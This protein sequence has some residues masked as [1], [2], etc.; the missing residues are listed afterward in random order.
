MDIRTAAIALIAISSIFPACTTPK[1]LEDPL[2]PNSRIR[3]PDFRQAIG[4]II[5][6]GVVGGNRVTTL[7]NGDQIFPSMLAAIRGAKKTIT[8][9]TFV[10]EKGDVPKAFAEAFAE[11][12]RAGVK[13]HLI[14]DAHGAKKSRVYHSMMETAGVQIVKYHPIFALD[15]RRYNNRTHRKLLVIDGKVAF[16]GGVGIADQWSGNAQSPEHWRDSHYRIEGPAVAQIQGAFI[17]NWMASRHELLF[18]PDYFP[19]LPSA[20]TIAGNV[21]YSA[22]HK[23][24]YSVPLMY[25][26]AI[27]SA[28]ES[29]LIEN[30]YF[31][32]SE[33]LLNA[34]IAAANRGVKIEIIVP[35][36]HID[37]KAV[38]RASHKRWAKLL[39]AGIRI[40]EYK[41]TMIH[42]KL[43]IADGLFVSVGSANFDSRSLHLNDEAN[44]DVL[45][46]NFAAEQA[47]LFRR[48]RALAEPMTEENLKH[49][50]LIEKPIQAVQTPVEGQL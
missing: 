15:V 17:E 5:G 33:R 2:P 46:R 32:P 11:R 49:G 22:P 44:F 12:A 43:L 10:F 30:A 16:I 34:L 45:D 3:D 8:F 38:R 25:E 19:P 28:R 18:G 1:L 7:V 42:C 35:G 50:S 27:A 4:S 37:Q 36:E 40:Y 13:V 31:V 24:R 21:F 39:S 20:G 23:G 41:P 14:L 9:E 26:L 48:D 47:V 29:L 6:S